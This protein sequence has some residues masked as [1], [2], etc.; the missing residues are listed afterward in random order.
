MVTIESNLIGD[1]EISRQLCVSR[2]WVRK[3]RFHRRHQM[4]HVLDIDPV[5]LGSMPRYRL[6]DFNQW[7]GLLATENRAGKAGAND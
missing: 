6:E 1:G 3:Q 5:I 7:L 2:S 4:P